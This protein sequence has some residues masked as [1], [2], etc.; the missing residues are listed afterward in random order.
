MLKNYKIV[1]FCVLMTMNILVS[2]T[3]FVFEP[4]LA[5]YKIA[6]QDLI[7]VY[8]SMQPPVPIQLE[9][10]NVIGA[11]YHKIIL[12]YVLEIQGDS[13]IVMS[14]YSRKYPYYADL[15]ALNAKFN[16][17]D[18]K[19]VALSK[20][21]PQA[22]KQEAVNYFYNQLTNSL[23]Q[24]CAKI[25]QGIAYTL[26]T[27]PQNLEAALIAYNLAW[28]AQTSTMKLTGFA[29]VTTFKENMTTWILNVYEAAISNL[30]SL[31]QK[32]E[33]K[34]D[35]YEQIA[36]CYET[37]AFVYTNNGQAQKATVEKQNAASML[38]QKKQFLQAATLTESA[39]KQ[40]DTARV[41]VSI[42][43]LNPTEQIQ[44]IQNLLNTISSAYKAYSNAL[45]I[46]TSLQ[47]SSAINNCNFEINQLK[48]DFAIRKIQLLWLYFVQ[49][50]YISTESADS[51][52]AFTDLKNF[53]TLSSSK[54]TVS[55][56]SIIQA[57]IDTLNLC[58]QVPN[59]FNSSF[60]ITS[61]LKSAI[62]SYQSAV[63]EVPSDQKNLE[64]KDSFLVGTKALNELQE[65]L[66]YFIEII[67]G[68]IEIGQGKSMMSGSDILSQM[69]IQAQ[70]IDKIFAKNSLLKNFFFYF[71][72]LEVD[73]KEKN[74]F[75]SFV[76]QY[77]YR[78]ALS[79]VQSYV[80][81]SSPSQ[82]SEN[83]L[84]MMFALSDLIRIQGYKAYITDSQLQDLQTTII[85][86]AK[87]MNIE[88][89]AQKI[90]KQAQNGNNWVNT[91]TPGNG[92]QSETDSLW[93]TAISLCEIGIDLSIL[94]N[95]AT[96]SKLSTVELQKIYIIIL[97]DYITAFTTKAPQAIGSQLHIFVS[98]YK[99][100]TVA[101]LLNT[102][103]STVFNNESVIS[104]AKQTLTQL[105]GGS[106]GFFSQANAAAS[107]VTVVG[108]TAS[109][110]SEK[111]KL[112]TQ[113]MN[114]INVT[115]EQQSLAM[116]KI[117]QLLSLSQAPDPL[118][119]SATSGV[120]I[121]LTMRLGGT[122][123]SAQLTNP[124]A[125][126]INKLTSQITATQTLAEKAEGK[127]DFTS[128]ATLYGNIKEYC[129]ELLPLLQSSSQEK[130]YK[131]IYFLANT[132][133]TA[134]SL[135]VQV[136]AKN[137]T[138]IS[139][140]TNVPQNYYAQSYHLNNV[141]MQLL[142]GLVPT[143]LKT[144]TTLTALSALQIKDA[145]AIVKAYIIS[146]LLQSQGMT[147]SSC[148]TGYLLQKQAG[149]SVKNNKILKSIESQVD[150]YLKQ[151]ENIG[152]S[153]KV[154]GTVIDFVLNELPISPVTPFY[155]GAPSAVEYFTGAAELFQP[156]TALVDGGQY[157]PGQDEASYK[158]M[159]ESV[160]YAYVISAQKKLDSAQK[161]ATSLTANLTKSLKSKKSIDEVMFMQEYNKIKKG[162]ISAQS[163]FFAEQD[164]AYSYFNLAQQSA[165]AQTVKQLFLNS[166]SQQ[167]DIMS[168][169]LVGNPVS[170]MYNSVLSDLNQ[171]Y[172]SWSVELDPE[173]DASKIAQNKKKVVELFET[174]GDACMNYAYKQTMFP[175]L[176]QYHYMTAASN[177]EAAKQQYISMLNDNQQGDVMRNKALQ[178][179]FFACIQKMTAYYYAKTNGV[180]YTPVAMIGYDATISTTPTQISFS[181]LIASY[182]SFENAGNQNQGKIDAYNDV[183][184]LLL[185]AAMYI[186][187]LS[188]VYE[189]KV[190]PS[191]S[192]KPKAKAKVTLD[193][194]LLSYLQSKNI[195]AAQ[196]NVV[197]YTQS[198]ILPKLFNMANQVFIKFQNNFSALADWCN[199]LYTAIQYQYIDD[200]QGGIDTSLSSVDQAAEFSK[201]WQSFSIAM[202]KESSALENPSS[203]YVG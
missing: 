31:L 193:P 131:D 140:L 35:L 203:A 146:Q 69:M 18:Q 185:D 70:N 89:Y 87:V 98:L 110:K 37:L 161:T 118:L 132:R 111:E 115:I 116:N 143:S 34:V 14:A 175:N 191:Q 73:M 126:K 104:F 53:Y 121:N 190:T 102:S 168:K 165:K 177:Y 183:Q 149:I 47:D 119:I 61:L 99:L 159:L 63:T 167:V 38:S 142:G 40:A 155:S 150:A 22:L 8:Q 44:N 90:Y 123:Y 16:K 57:L 103:Q 84:A 112:I 74:S 56:D 5:Q 180:M 182:Q 17:Y 162:I 147:F 55:T 12:P 127:Q 39:K 97:Q 3:D 100:Y 50:K 125:V 48:G 181:D 151:W 49:N 109:E 113:L 158:T 174:A 129:L 114:Q 105:F 156:G 93:N 95:I 195:I 106:N 1:S 96:V 58:T 52:Q 171:V 82:G 144:L 64:K 28:K 188:G 91:A 172:L 198:N 42:D 133:A 86:L 152:I 197:S 11:T 46:Y 9:Q 192:N 27:D 19:V 30:T 141:D 120:M 7:N 184:K 137:M 117:V 41:N 62:Q 179:Y 169:F 186:Q 60:S 13:N 189:A 21:F 194:Q 107:A 68:M 187:Y 25:L 54:G 163:L 92:Y 29:D 10:S 20:L 43:F 45:I 65:V 94:P 157:V 6:L 26:N 72:D 79:K 170:N 88:Q 124:I 145:V 166:Y 196:G 138:T 130:A 176:Q 59:N 51:I 199:C 76:V 164:S 83:E 77:V 4:I 173:K 2:S 66:N 135:A 153:A 136:I 80:T 15:K 202:Q 33:N 160:A 75:Q 122:S 81:P 201:K 154:S 178:A 71:P 101:T 108:I 78:I 67:N 128:S 24:N 32:S 139:S 200:Y 134:A 85:A 23:V 148:Y 36:H